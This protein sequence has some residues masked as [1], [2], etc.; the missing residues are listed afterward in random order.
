MQSINHRNNFKPAWKRQS[1][2]CLFP[3]HCVQAFLAWQRLIF[4]TDY[5]IAVIGRSSRR[6]VNEIEFNRG[7]V[8]IPSSAVRSRKRRMLRNRLTA[9]SSLSIFRSR[10]SSRT[11]NVSHRDFRDP[12]PIFLGKIATRS[13]NDAAVA[14][15]SIVL[16]LGRRGR[17]L[18]GSR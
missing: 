2:R 3:I 18:R 4:I 12:W 9:P 15:T 13:R 7:T 5:A 6:H 16:A 14:I 1:C 8:K 11:R 17:G 10:V